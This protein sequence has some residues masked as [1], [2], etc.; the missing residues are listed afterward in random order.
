[1]KNVYKNLML[2][3]FHFQIRVLQRD[4]L[5]VRGALLIRVTRQ[6]VVSYI[7]LYERILFLANE[8]YFLFIVL[9]V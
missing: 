9:I 5:Q 7:A 2:Q 1:M 4:A 8:L 6:N 3:F